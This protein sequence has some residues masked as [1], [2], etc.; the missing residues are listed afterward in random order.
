MKFV[1]RAEFDESPIL[2][3]IAAL[4]KMNNV[5]LSG[6]G[7]LQVNIYILIGFHI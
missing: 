4:R 6:S 2:L 5:E 7:G 3:Y 1:G